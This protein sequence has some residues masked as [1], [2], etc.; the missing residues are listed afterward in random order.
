M[1]NDLIKT[2][3][4]ITPAEK[5]MLDGNNFDKNVY[6]V[7]ADYVIRS[8]RLLGDK[9][10][11]ATRHPRFCEFP[12]HGHD[13][14][15]VMYVCSGEITHVI[16]GE[17]VKVAQ[18][19]LL[20]LNKHVRHSIMRADS[21]DLGINFVLSDNFLSAVVNRHGNDDLLTK[22]VANNLKKDG[23]AQYLL[24]DIGDVYPVRN[25]LDNLIYTVASNDDK[26]APLLPKLVALLLDYLS[27]HTENVTGGSA[28]TD[29]TAKFRRAVNDYLDGNYPTATLTELSARTGLN[30]QYLSRKISDVYGKSFKQLL[31]EQ[32][33]LAAEKLFADTSLNVDEVANAVGYENVSHFY[34][35]FEGKHGVTPSHWRKK[36]NT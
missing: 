15:E 35:V 20:L 22:F 26:D 31:T 8:A 1:Q 13:Y 12:L 14:M 29:P 17:R 10:M 32:R 5:A 3:G 25:L 16:E 6:N 7:A 2:L 36:N 24:Y 11:V 23:N 4:E 9:S 28:E 27:L 34:R 19:G 33:L 18:G 21:D 30:A